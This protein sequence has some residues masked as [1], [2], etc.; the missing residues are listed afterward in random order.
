M[1]GRARHGARAWG[2]PSRPTPTPPCSPA[3]PT[4]APLARLPAHQDVSGNE[5]LQVRAPLTW[6]LALPR[7]RWLDLRAIHREDS[8][9]WSGGSDAQGGWGGV[10]GGSRHLLCHQAPYHV[11]CTTRLACCRLPAHGSRPASPA[12]PQG[13]T[14]P[15]PPPPALPPPPAAQT[16][17]A[18]RC[19]TWQRWPRRCGGETDRRACCTTPAEQRA[20]LGRCPRL[21]THS[22]FPP[23]RA[24]VPPTPAP[25]RVHYCSSPPPCLHPRTQSDCP[26]R[27]TLRGTPRCPR[28][29]ACTHPSSPLPALPC[30]PP[31]PC[32]V[33][34]M[35]PAIAAQAL[36]VCSSGCSGGGGGG[37]KGT[38]IIGKNERDGG[39]QGA[40]E[41]KNS[42]G[43]GL[44][45]RRELRGVSC[46]RVGEGEGDA[47]AHARA[48][49]SRRWRA[50][51][52]QT[53]QR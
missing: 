1:C 31:P 19:S 44:A 17:S 15:P 3:R 30:C 5:F 53:P 51:C 40:T 52:R 37:I 29:H 27:S 24:R 33:C 36:C 8:R 43:G 9:F 50:P 14:S 35:R 47:R 18:R 25:L 2:V 16:Q 12:V 45:A 23:P 28:T 26:Q 10:G 42:R 13:Q 4:P 11:T 49:L 20:A 38:H 48:S 21:V 7:V 34:M 41:K 46:V 32:C 6:M 39:E 22:L